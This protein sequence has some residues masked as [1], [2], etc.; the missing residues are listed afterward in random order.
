MSMLKTLHSHKPCT[1]YIQDYLEG[2][3]KTGE[4]RHIGKDWLN[5]TQHEAT[6]WAAV[7]DRTREDFGHTG[8]YRGKHS[9]TYTH[10]IISPDP[11]DKIDLETLQA[12]TKDWATEFFGDGKDKPGRLGQYEVA[13]VYHDDNEQH[14]PHAHLIVNHSDLIST[15]RMQISDRMM[16][17]DLPDHLQ[18][19][20]K[21]YGLRYFDNPNVVKAKT[22]QRSD[23]YFTKAERA[24]L[25]AGKFSWKHELA[26]HVV[27]AKHLSADMDGFME[28][29]KRFGVDV[30]EKDGDL[31]FSH[32]HNRAR[33]KV[34]GKRLGKAYTKEAICK[35]FEQAPSVYGQ[36][37]RHDIIAIIEQ[38]AGAK[39]IGTIPATHKTTARE[40]L[41]TLRVMSAYKITS[42]KDFTKQERECYLKMKRFEGTD[43]EQEA[44]REYAKLKRAERFAKAHNLFESVKDLGAE[45]EKPAKTSQASAKKRQYDERQDTHKPAKPQTQ[46][47]QVR[48]S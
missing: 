17:K 7:M 23:R 9:I 2:F 16:K 21:R 12:L 36:A 31:I 46:T 25:R 44:K 11:R 13:I 8:D 4:P 39:Y 27:L 47:R 43:R 33:W 30:R 3:N 45:Q 15:R 24:I 19:L 40:A 20:S 37:L 22:L 41:Y 10:F 34:S 6:R 32:A 26:T 1:M 48:R 29:M 18:V 35:H 5:L 42:L 14:I 28:A 38:K